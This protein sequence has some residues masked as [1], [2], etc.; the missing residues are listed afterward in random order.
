[1]KK[2]LKARELTSFSFVIILFILVGI[3]NPGF[4]APE[5]LLLTLNSSV[6]FTLLAAG[7][8]FIIISG[9]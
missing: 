8:A 5:N 7:T 4:L 6:V 9:E 1:M 2:L 3:V